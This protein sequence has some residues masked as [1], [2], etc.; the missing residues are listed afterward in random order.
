MKAVKGFSF[1]RLF[2]FQGRVVGGK[3]LDGRM[4]ID[5]C[6][7]RAA[8]AVFPDS[9]GSTASLPLGIRYHGL[10]DNRPANIMPPVGATKEH[11]YDALMRLKS[12]FLCKRDICR[13]Y[14]SR[15]NNRGKLCLKRKQFGSQW[16]AYRL[17]VSGRFFIPCFLWKERELQP[18][19][20]VW[21]P[22]LFHCWYF[23]MSLILWERD[24]DLEKWSKP[25]LRYLLDLWRI[26]T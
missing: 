1:N 13:G 18:L 9:I 25:Q 5:L 12:A 6:Y 20:P 23:I 4:I 7:V 16:R 19:A 11:A 8:K 10:S 24:L 15:V 3:G 14:L 17:S 2:L 22:R 21:W 26:Y